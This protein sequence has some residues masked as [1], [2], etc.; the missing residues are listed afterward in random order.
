MVPAGAFT[1]A[2]LAGAARSARRLLADQPQSDAARL[3]AAATMFVQTRLRM[4][5]VREYLLDALGTYAGLQQFTPR[6]G[7]AFDTAELELPVVQLTAQSSEAAALQ[8]L[9]LSSMARHAVRGRE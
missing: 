5:D 2:P 8:F 4:Q 1:P 6:R 7:S 3:G 9:A